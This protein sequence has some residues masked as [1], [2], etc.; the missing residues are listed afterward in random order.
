MGLIFQEG[1]SLC[2][3]FATGALRTGPHLKFRDYPAGEAEVFICI[4]TILTQF[5]TRKRAEPAV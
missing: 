1:N 5:C 3:A 2:A 4:Q